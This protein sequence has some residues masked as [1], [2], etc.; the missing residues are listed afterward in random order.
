MIISRFK[1]F[2]SLSI[3]AIERGEYTELIGESLDEGAISSIKNFFSKMLGGAVDKLDKILRKYREAELEYW[4]DWADARSRM[5]SADT[6]FKDAKD[7]VNRSKYE[8]QKER[9]KRLAIQVDAK[10]KD[11]LE[12]LRK[13]ADHIIKDSARLK[14]YYEMKRTKIDEEVARESFEIVKKSTDDTTI[15]DL[16]DN[17]IAAAVKAAREKYGKFQEKYGDIASKDSGFFKDIRTEDDGELRVAGVKIADIIAR[18]LEEIQDQIKTMHA[19][20]L[21]DILKY[22]EKEAKKT[23]EKR[24]EEI[25]RLKVKVTDKDQLSAGIEDVMKKCRATLESIEKKTNYIDQL[26][27]SVHNIG[28]EIKKNPQIVTDKTPDELGPH[29]T[30]VAVNTA[31]AKA[32]ANGNPTVDNVEAVIDSKVRSNFENAKEII[33]ESLGE[34][35]DDGAYKH[36]VNDLVALYGKLVFF[37]K[38]MKQNVNAR[39]LEIG[40]VDFAAQLYKEKK[41]DGQL[42]RNLSDKELEKKFEKYAK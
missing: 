42:N 7:Q 26:L 25:K 20:A 19:D 13:Q 22:L 3:G 39:T 9:V 10:H 29:N 34:P 38:D 21:G 23:K 32:S 35:I 30:T 2:E 12:S 14:D 36:I 17:H 33:E 27:L 1:M 24:D 18:P 5:S 4:T 11:I 28:K 37:Y 16:F 31:I 8:E 15:H 40:L 6:L 41:K